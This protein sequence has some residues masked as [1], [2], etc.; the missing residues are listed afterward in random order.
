[1]GAGEGGEGGGAETRR[2]EGR[3]AGL[4]DCGTVRLWDGRGRH[5]GRP[6]CG[7]VIVEPL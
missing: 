4:R 3:T 7:N 1:M 5:D 6:E 2:R